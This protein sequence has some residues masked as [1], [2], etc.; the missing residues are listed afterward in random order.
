MGKAL[1]FD[2]ISTWSSRRLTSKVFLDAVIYSIQNALIGF[3]LSLQLLAR[4]SLSSLHSKRAEQLF[5]QPIFNNL[6]WRAL[7]YQDMRHEPRTL[8]TVS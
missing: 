5:L 3:A 1:G 6:H 2:A 8:T 7:M 4:C